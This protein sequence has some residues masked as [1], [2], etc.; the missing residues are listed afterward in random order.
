MGIVTGS[1]DKLGSGFMITMSEIDAKT[2]E[3]IARAQGRVS[4]DEDLLVEEMGERPVANVMEQAGHSQ[5]LDDQA[6]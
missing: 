2:L 1:L 4:T 5:G 3:A 6:F